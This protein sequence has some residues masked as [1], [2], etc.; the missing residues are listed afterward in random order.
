MNVACSIC[1]ESFT[2]TSDIYTT[3]CGHVF[4]YECIRKWLE[5]GNPHCS[6]CRQNCEINEIIRLIFSENESALEENYVHTQLESENIKLQK[7]VNESKAQELEANKK[8]TQL[9]SENLKFQKEINESKARE[10][11]ANKTSTQ[12]QS[13][14]FK[15]KQSV[16]ASKAREFEANQECVRLKEKHQKLCETFRQFRSD[17]A[18]KERVLKEQRKEIDIKDQKI[19]ELEAKCKQLE[20]SPMVMVNCHDS[21]K[22]KL[23]KFSNDISYYE[24]KTKNSEQPTASTSQA[25]QPTSSQG[26]QSVIFVQSINAATDPRPNSPV[27]DTQKGQCPMC[28]E[29]FNRSILERHAAV[30]EGYPSYSPTSPSYSPTSPSYSPTSPSYSPTSPSYSPTSPSYSPTSPSYTP[31]SPS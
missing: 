13:E 12:H 9:E 27:F 10:L 20:E 11:E 22:R 18:G 30:C 17:S 26:N 4:H 25:N 1:L 8:S 15:L 28:L 24:N 14:N 19:S 31:R 6:L 29:M 21:L 3:P 7:E 16:N 2:L 5:R 23:R